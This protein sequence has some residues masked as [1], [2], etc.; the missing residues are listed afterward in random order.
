MRKIAVVIGS[1]ANWGR[2]QSVC[3]AVNDH[4]DLELQLITGASGIELPID[5][6]E[7][8]Q[9][10]VE[11][12]N[13]QAMVLT[14]GLFLTQIGGVLER[15]QPDFVL[16]HGDRH[17]ILAPAMAAA[18]M[19]IPLAHTEGGDISGTIDQKVRY[20][21]TALADI[22]FPVTE[23]S[24]KR[25]IA[26]GANPDR[27]FTVGSTALDSLVDLD[28]TNNRKE[29]Y[30]LVL[31]H[32]NT[33]HPEDITPLIEAVNAIPLKKVWVNPN[34]DPGSKAM[35]KII[36]RQDV[37]FVKHLSPEEYARLLYNCQCAVGNS[38]SFIKEGAFL[39]V[40]A[41][42]VGRRQEGREVGGNVV[43]AQNNA[44]SIESSIHYQLGNRPNPDYC[45]GNG[46]AGKLV[47]EIL[48]KIEG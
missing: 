41:V 43:L 23:F 40:P 46:M 17:E 48:S 6:P 36:H 10:L 7:R 30:I 33:T 9:C 15:L 29:P 25:I 35:L 20:A 3:K 37:E 32:P 38:S 24:A 34:V 14:T 4:P 28:L 11:G 2:L 27:V 39:G 5:T 45:F 22:H 1:R 19:N 44:F 31:H 12:D 42:L 16:V 18:Y 47:A 26:T 21:I 8:I 13:H